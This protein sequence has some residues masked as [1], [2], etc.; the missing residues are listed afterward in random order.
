M[1]FRED[2]GHETGD[3]M[4][5]GDHRQALDQDRPQTAAVEV[6]G[7]LDRDFRAR[8]IELNVEGVSDQQPGLIVGDQTEVPNTNFYRHMSGA[9]HIRRASEEPQT[10]SLDA[11]SRKEQVQSGLIGG[12]DRAHRNQ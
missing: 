12:S 3:S 1:V 4:L 9:A 5:L 8:A 10:A 6:I 7:Y 11:Q 2:L